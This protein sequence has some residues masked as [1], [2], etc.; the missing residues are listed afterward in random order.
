MSSQEAQTRPAPTRVDIERVEATIIEHY[1]RLV[2]IAYLV[3][4]PSLGRNRRVR[5]AHALTQR[6]LPRRGRASST[7]P[8][9]VPAPRAAE[10]AADHDYAYVRSRVLTAALEAAVPLRTTLRRR[11]RPRRSQLPP[12]LPRFW[13]LQLLPRS[14]GAAELALNQRL[15]A[16]S[17][18]A[19]AACALRA[20]EGLDEEAI[21]R[22][23]SEAGVSDPHAALSEAALVE[24]GGQGSGQTPRSGGPGQDAAIPLLA[25]PGFDPCLLQARPT[26]LLRRR[27]YT[28]AGLAATAALLVA[29]SLF[30]LAGDEGWGADGAAAPPYATNA[31]VEL[32]L[33]PTKLS[34]VKPTAWQDAS[35]SDFSVWPARGD[36]TDDRALLRRALAVWARPGSGVQVSATP[37]TPPGP[38]MGPPQ[39]LFAGEV[40]QAVVVLLYDGL[41]VVRYAEPAQGRG[42]AV[43]DF[44]RADG[45]R[46]AGAVVVTR[47][48]GNVRYLTAPW[49]RTAAVRDLL[50]PAQEPTPLRLGEDGVTAPLRSPAQDASCGTWNALALRDADA[51]RL[52]TDLGEILPAGLTS[53]APGATEEIAGAEDLSHWARTACLLPAMRSQGV[54]A[55]NSWQFA[56]QELP[57][58]NGR[59]DWLCTRAQTWR[60]TGEQVFVQFQAP[61]AKA[62]EPG[63]LAARSQDTPACGAR[64]PQVLAGV[65][66]KSRGGDW[67][68]LAAGSKQF[69]SLAVSG[70]VSGVS[71][72]RLL[73]LPS[74]QGAQVELEGRLTDG[75]TVGVLR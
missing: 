45:D 49:V 42:A 44:A 34:R 1:P 36:R 40:D 71:S 52:T 70:G 54:R 27:R 67:F 12:L 5:T 3:L 53:G 16:V 8:S 23:L 9:L 66:W 32:A 22:A 73:T 6:A 39:L 50:R 56:E 31:A 30:T 7:G 38:P 72:G 48:D 26:D 29:G 24:P 64:K 46:R 15:A 51:T 60:G 47:I 62:G 57:Q 14:A 18:P 61:T 21:R 17:G 2:R 75:S 65:L 68:V 43:L 20:L 33:D 41:R 55:V 74:K 37:G 25:S 11:G 63:A 69:T 13:G 28:R 58:D 35:R 4:P 59:A 10:F 19:R